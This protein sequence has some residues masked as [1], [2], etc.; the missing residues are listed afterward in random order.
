[1]SSAAKWR[2]GC[3]YSI[4]LVTLA[5]GIITSP[6]WELG[7]DLVGGWALFV[8]RVAPRIQ[9]N[10]G[11]ICTGVLA[12]LA[13]SFGLHRFMCWLYPHL[14]R[15]VGQER[16]PYWTVRWTRQIVTLILFLFVA[17][18]AVVGVVH[19]I[20]WLVTTT[21]PMT[22]DNYSRRKDELN[23]RR[24]A[25]AIDEYQEK[26]GQ[27]VPGATCDSDGRMLHSWTTLVMPY[28]RSSDVAQLDWQKPWNAPENNRQLQES[29]PYY[30]LKH[31]LYDDPKIDGLSPTHYSANAWVMGG[32]RKRPP[33]N[34]KDEQN[35][36]VLIGEAGGNFRPWP[37]PGNW[38][39]PALGVNRS[40]AGFGSPTASRDVKFLFSDGSVQTIRDD[41]DQTVFENLCRP[42]ST[43][44]AT[45]SP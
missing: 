41:I 27:L 31:R 43:N 10:V 9:L 24:I 20:V 19:Q 23:L 25:Y 16:E 15:I 44:S 1:M 12:L 39:D 21:E 18:I 6:L 33:V 28:L 36:T 45:P 26:H 13:F 22:V 17:G 32:T 8:I 2:T 38:R 3:L 30:F 35:R 40:P 29:L 34:F 4:F 14:S 7:I 5:T 37:E 42:K 11:G